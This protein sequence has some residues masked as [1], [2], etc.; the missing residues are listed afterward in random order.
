MGSPLAIRP[1]SVLTG[2]A[3]PISRHTVGQELLLIAV[4][5]EAAFGHMDD[6][7]AGIGVLEW[8]T[9][10]SSG[11]TGLFERGPRGVDGG[12]DVLLDG[13][14]RRVHLVGAVGAGAN[15]TAFRGTGLSV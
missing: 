3:L 5:A 15:S 12:R 7:C 14:E 13:R 10:T 9:S 6:L 1:P 8:I 11:A 2:M 4:G